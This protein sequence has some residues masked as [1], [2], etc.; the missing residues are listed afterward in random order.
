MGVPDSTARAQRSLNPDSATPR[1]GRRPRTAGAGWDSRGGTQGR[2]GTSPLARPRAPHLHGGLDVILRQ[3]CD[4]RSA[5][6]AKPCERDVVDDQLP[7]DADVERPAFLLELPGGQAAERREASV[8]APVLGQ[9]VWRLRDGS[10][11][12][13]M[14]AL[15]TRA[16]SGE[17]SGFRNRRAGAKYPRWGAMRNGFFALLLGSSPPR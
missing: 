5:E 4:P 6:G 15:M 2:V 11:G 1:R 13:V 14:R 12:E 10:A 8:D 16:L 17:R 9:V 3:V 7:L